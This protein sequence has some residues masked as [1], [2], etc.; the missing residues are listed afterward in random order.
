VGE[1]LC[2]FV[3]VD[4]YGGGGEQHVLQVAKLSCK[5]I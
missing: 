1:C 5:I 4:L 3:C 2:G